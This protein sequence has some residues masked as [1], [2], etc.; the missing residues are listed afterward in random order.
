MTTMNKRLELDE[1]D[2]RY[3]LTALVFYI[4]YFN[5]SGSKDIRKAMMRIANRIRK[6]K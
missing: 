4:H 5:Q 3:V 1:H 2:M 6:K